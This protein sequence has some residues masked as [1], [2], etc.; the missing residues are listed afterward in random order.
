[1]TLVSAMSSTV[2]NMTTDQRLALSPEHREAYFRYRWQL[3]LLI[4]ASILA[5]IRL[6]THAPDRADSNERSFSSR[7]CSAF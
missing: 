4:W 7:H 3:E 6:G 5:S 2:S 1:M